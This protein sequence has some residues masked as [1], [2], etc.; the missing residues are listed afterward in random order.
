M[1]KITTRCDG[2]SKTFMLEGKL[3]EPWAQELEHCW[4]AALVSQQAHLVRVDLTGVTFI[5]AAG[6]ALLTLMARHGAELV[7]VECMTKAIVEDITR[8]RLQ[9]IDS[10]ITKGRPR[11]RR[12][13]VR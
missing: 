10:G 9:P 4:R 12:G 2:E 7:A 6:K 5:D 11:S 13:N 8:G 1:L 3:A